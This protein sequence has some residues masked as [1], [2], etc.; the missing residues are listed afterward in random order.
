MLISSFKIQRNL[1]FTITFDFNGELMSI[2]Q[3]QE[4]FLN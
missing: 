4:Y 3:K 1:N 2:N